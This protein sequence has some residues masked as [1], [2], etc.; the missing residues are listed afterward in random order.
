[1]RK[2]GRLLAVL[3]AVSMTMT[4]ALQSA[5]PVMAEESASTVSEAD[6]SVEEGEEYAS[7]ES[8]TS[9]S[10]ESSTESLDAEA[11]STE[12]EEDTR[13]SEDA[14]SE[15][16]VSEEAESIY[17]I[18]DVR[19][20]ATDNASY[21]V[22]GVVSYINGKSVYIQ[23]DTAA[24]VVFLAEKNADIKIGSLVTATGTLT[25]YN[26]LIELNKAA[27]DKVEDT[28]RSYDYKIINADELSDFA[29]NY[30]DYEAQKV[31]LEGVTFV[32][33]SGKKAIVSASNTEVVL[34]YTSASDFENI[35]E[36]SKVNVYGVVS[37]YKGL[38]VIPCGETKIEAAKSADGSDELTADKSVTCTAASWAGTGEVTFTDVYAD[39][40]AANDGK[41][42]SNVLTAVIDG[43]KVIPDYSY[44]SGGNKCHLIGT[45]GMNSDDYYQ[46]SVDGTGYGN[47]KL[48]FTMRSSGT[49][50]ANWKVSYS[51]DGEEFTTLSDEIKVINKAQEY[52]VE[53]PEAVINAENLFIRVF[54]ANDTSVN[55]KTVAAGG[56]NRFQN[57]S[58]TA[59]PAKGGKLTGYVSFEPEDGEVAAGDDITLTCASSDADIYYSINGS[60][61]V[62]YDP[63]KK[64][65]LSSNDF[66][67]ENANSTAKA[68]V[69]AYAVKNEQKSV[70]TKVVYTPS[71][72][73]SV[74]AAPNG[75][76]VKLG[77]KVKLL[78][79]TEGAV[80]TYS[81]DG[82]ETWKEYT[83]EITLDTLPA[84]IIAKASKPGFVES[85]SSNFT[86]TERE[87]DKYNIYFGQLHSHTSYSDGAGTADDAFSYASN[88]A[89]HVDFLAVTDHSNLL[90]NDTS[91]T[92]NDG[93][94]SSEWK[95]GHQLADNYTTDQ[96][97]GIFGYEMTWSG[98][99]PGHINT[100]NTDGFMSRNMSGYES[101]SRTALQNYYSQ[102]KATPDSMSMF[103]H[104]GT[105]FGDF[106]DFAYYDEEIDKQITLIEV[107]NGEGAIG[108]SGYFP[109][110]EYYQRAL[111]KGWHLAPANNQDNHKGKWGDAN[112]GRSVVLADSLT[113]DNI[114]DAI[115]NR[116][117]YATEDN[118]LNIYYTL[119]G[120]EMG[121]IL[122]EKPEKVS[123]SVDL[124]D[125]TD[126]GK[127]KVHVIANG[128]VVVAETTANEAEDT[129]TF[130]L[131]PDYAFYYIKVIQA[132]GDIAV[133]APVW[134]TD[135]EAIGV[136][137]VETDASLE[138]AGEAINVNT[139][140]FNNEADDFEVSSIVYTANGQV[141][142]TTDLTDDLKVMEKQ[143]E[144]SDSFSF[145]YDKAGAVTIEAVITGY[146]NGQSKKYTGSLALNYI[147]EDMVTHVVI[148][149]S[150]HN[151][152]VTGYYGGNVGNFADIAA[153]DYVK[154]DVVTDEITDK[155]LEDASVFVVSAPA[156][157]S[158]NY[159]E[160][161]YA[162]THF[163]DSFL[164][165]VKNYVD[166]GGNLIVCGIAD[167]SDSK[168]TQ[169]STEINKLL[170]YIGATTRLNS[171]EMCDDENN[172]G[173]SYRLYFTD[174][175]T[176]NYLLADVTS[177]Q[178][179]SAYSGSSV[180]A[181]PAAVSAGTAS[182]LV[183]GHPTT[184][185]LDSKKYDDN[186]VAVN[187][188][189]VSALV[190]EKLSG[191]GEMLVAGTVFV[192][193]FEVK[194]DLD[195]AGDSYYANR[196]ILLNYL[197]AHKKVAKVSTIAE[198]R[199][200]NQGDIFTI[201][202][203]VTAGTAVEGNKFFD[204]IYVQ[205]ETAGTTVFPISE[206][207]I[208]I[209]TKLQITG[210]VDGYQGDKEIQ[211]MSYKVIK[212]DTC[213]YEP[214]KVTTAQ[215][216]D[217]DTYGGQLLEVEGE[218][219][220]VITNSAGVDYFFV[221]DESG[222]EA[223][224][225]IDGYILAADGKDTVNEDVKVGN[226]I[227]AAGLCYYNPDGACLRVR[228][229]DEVVKTNSFEKVS[230]KFVKALG[231][232]FFKTPEGERL[233]GLHLIDGNYYY[234]HEN[235]GHMATSESIKID[236]KT[237][238][239]ARDGKRYS[240]LLNSWGRTYYYAAD[241]AQVF[242][243]FVVIDDKTYYFNEKGQMVK[244]K[245]L[246]IDG[247][248]YHFNTKGEMTRGTTIS[249]WG[250]KYS[251]DEN[252]VLI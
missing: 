206:E 204:T 33:V 225:F 194:S 66:L 25:E 4:T 172:G 182:V 249:I 220:K 215:A 63:E 251:F 158:G 176:D 39:L 223:R 167:Y 228:N 218:V 159:G 177:E 241:G 98:G 239:F 51:T 113:R 96:F 28:D 154:V 107:G 188:G 87:G 86:Y 41:D 48:N 199:K 128:G 141:I 161:S 209:G 148:D 102:L 23:D 116:R 246:E 166:N 21:T 27:V 174:F 2:R 165:V 92:I 105:T 178:K 134:L 114:Y 80:I 8:D 183:K 117:L 179:Y 31:K 37:D 7:T 20:K 55:K 76:A 68:I 58:V 205:D 50:A 224:V 140:F 14:V 217:Y 24:I 144:M 211:V 135:V 210:Y 99:A 54:P 91:V 69:R 36:G 12:S 62:E 122:D 143:S 34:W 127:E 125:K 16:N 133:T 75:G 121:T 18:A 250:K 5:M 137:S 227:R 73:T 115:R 89:E 187:K 81:L 238:H 200:G 70:V 193:N 240:G 29:E 139:T 85:T 9:E 94:A 214:K 136:S 173:Q 11:G 189:D 32:S 163:E 82:G 47:Y 88:N 106:Y 147:T 252:G 222:K 97:V 129:V 30:K 149:G 243:D 168:D 191:G 229:R 162:A 38:Q 245:L 61:Y 197:A 19:N 195:N 232:T 170:S 156:K 196:N 124:L 146:L 44:T 181:D 72:T 242:N 175:N 160:I 59:N 236:G 219:T 110:Y 52:S 64:F 207:G 247:K 90:D 216:A 233:K 49:G 120:N 57:I 10:D 74:T 212:D 1:M 67:A 145:T 185:S 93:S 103:N 35:A 202:G 78:T 95:E 138:V 84:S 65:S 234:F 40:D 3:L 235:N 26:G 201:E 131:D 237:Y 231:R 192:S 132:D 118:D 169:S 79:K 190:S 46:L 198:M 213:V 71:T 53:L 60:E 126:S 112:T 151:D 180:I 130:E 155:T 17:A 56:V 171:D 230:G 164:K 108:S 22:Q 226:T 104:P 15:D 244:S 83:E 184:Y 100:F 123:I 42:K 43:E 203:Y 157:K 153:A 45:K 119:N 101:Q 221:R 6:I 186:Y 208:K 142:H 248:K 77:T 109:S 13:V 150:H 111:D 152:Y